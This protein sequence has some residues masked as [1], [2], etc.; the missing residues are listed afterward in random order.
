MKEYYSSNNV[1]NLAHYKLMTE[2]V[3]QCF[4]EP[5][6][7]TSNVSQTRAAIALRTIEDRINFADSPLFKAWCDCND[8]ISYHKIKKE[9]IK[10]NEEFKKHICNKF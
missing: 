9:L 3:K 5:K 10:K 8:S 6:P 7:T 4:F 1:S 2:V